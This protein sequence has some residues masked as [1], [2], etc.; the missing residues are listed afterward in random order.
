MIQRVKLMPVLTVCRPVASSRCRRAAGSC[1]C[2]SFGRF[3]S[4]AERL[5]AGHRDAAELRVPG[6]KYSDGSSVRF[7]TL[8]VSS[9]GR[10]H[11]TR[12]TFST[13][14]VKT[15]LCSA[16]KNRESVWCAV[17][18]VADT[19]AAA[20]CAGAVVTVAHR[21]RESFSEKV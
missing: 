2:R 3:A 18:P 8:T 5:E 14:D 19:A 10:F 6:M 12:A 15:R 1:S 9:Y 16:A 11:A 17:R 4:R 20:I 7:I 21:R 13:R